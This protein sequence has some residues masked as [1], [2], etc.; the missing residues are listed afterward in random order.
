MLFR[1]GDTV[2][3]ATIAYLDKNA[4]ANKTVNLNAATL[5]DGNG[6]ANYSVSLAGN[7][8]SSIGARGLTLSPVTDSR[9]YDGTVNSAAAVGVV[10]AAAGDVVTATGTLHKDRDYG[11][12]YRYVVILDNTE[13]R[14]EGSGKK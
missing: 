7:S 4:G 6:G 12:G 11:G 8:T 1:S 2:S 14:I 9:T 5:N 10:G 13:Y 3:A